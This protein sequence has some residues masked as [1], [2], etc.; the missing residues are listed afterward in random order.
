M[1]ARWTSGMLLALAC[2]LGAQ[3]QDASDERP[4]DGSDLREPA[5][6]EDG[7]R[8]GRG[9]RG[10]MPLPPDWPRAG[11]F[12]PAAGGTGGS[13]A[14]RPMIE[15]L[16]MEGLLPASFGRRELTDADVANAVAVAKE[17]APEW[18]D[19][20]ETRFKED[21]ARARVL[22]R[23]SG[24]RLLGLVALKERA[25]VVFAAKVAELRAQAETNGAAEELSEAEARGDA[26]ADRLAELRRALE[27]ASQRQVEATLAARRAE[28]DALDQR[29]IKLREELAADAARKTELEREVAEQ[30]TQRG[31]KRPD[32]RPDSR[33][34][35]R[36]EA[37]PDTR[38]PAER[39]PRE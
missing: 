20:I 11:G 32:A 24:R 22:L 25:P 23:T 33:P 28:L 37:R 36:P 35:S 4:R 9:G 8:G 5:R 29:M 19:A 16:V 39:A 7:R 26:G 1:R 14:E 2:A 10:G 30:A 21:P 31:E 17:V 3:A 6:Q 27:L 13:G 34:D 38:D 12:G 15:G 18:G